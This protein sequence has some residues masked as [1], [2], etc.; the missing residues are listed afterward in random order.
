MDRPAT[1]KII[2]N[3]HKKL[4]PEGSMYSIFASN[5]DK[6]G[7][8]TPMEHTS[9]PYNHYPRKNEAVDFLGG[10]FHHD[11]KSFTHHF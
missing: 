3:W 5:P 8:Y 11:I 4:A 7:T 10:K 9:L 1:I 2:E 6:I